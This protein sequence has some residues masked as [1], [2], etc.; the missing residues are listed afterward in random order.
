MSFNC[1]RLLLS[2]Q[3]ITYTPF[4]K[5]KNIKQGDELFQTNF[6]ELIISYG[7]DNE[8]RKTIETK[9]ENGNITSTRTKFFASL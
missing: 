3:A 8:R 4:K 7:I 1:S 2:I 6:N 5:A 9:T